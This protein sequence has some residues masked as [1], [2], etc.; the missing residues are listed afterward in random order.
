MKQGMKLYSKAEIRL[1]NRVGR[2][3]CVCSSQKCAIE[4]HSNHMCFIDLVAESN[5][6]KMC[7]ISTSI[8]MDNVSKSQGRQENTNIWNKAN[9]Y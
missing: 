2:L 5:E 6:N 8:M 9:I 7:P 4:H 1:N 3:V